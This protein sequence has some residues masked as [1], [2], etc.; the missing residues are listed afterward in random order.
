MPCSSS[1][2]QPIHLRALP[3]PPST[4]NIAALLSILSTHWRGK[5]EHHDPREITRKKISVSQFPFEHSFN[6]LYFDYNFLNQKWL[7]ASHSCNYTWKRT[8]KRLSVAPIPTNNRKTHWYL[9]VKLSTILSTRLNSGKNRFSRIFTWTPILTVWMCVYKRSNTSIVK[10]SNHYLRQ[11][12][13]E[14]QRIS[15]F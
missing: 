7:K 14:L 8:N 1:I 10:Q 6:I 2:F 3:Y 4:E 5:R 11:V 12:I 9:T 13:A 15:N